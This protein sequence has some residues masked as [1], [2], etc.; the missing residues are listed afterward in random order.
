MRDA[1]SIRFA[2]VAGRAR[3]ASPAEAIRLLPHEWAF[4][5]LYAF[6]IARL[7]FAA[8]F[9]APMLGWLTLAATTLAL[10]AL[11][12]RFATPATRS[13]RLGAYIVLMNA[14]YF[15]VRPTVLATTTMRFDATLA[16]LDTAL[17]GAPLPLVAASLVPS[18]ANDLLGACYLLLFP[19]IV[20]SCTWF[21]LR[22]G[23]ADDRA[24]ERFF[25]AVF[26]TYAAGFAGYLLVPAAGPWVA[27]AGGFRGPL[28]GG[29]LTRLT[30]DVVRQGSTQVDVFPSLHVAVSAVIAAHLP[31]RSTWARLAV[32]IPTLGLWLSTVALRFHYGVDAVAGFLLAVAALA[33][34]RRLV[35]SSTQV[36]A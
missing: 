9:G 36:H 14:A 22:A 25:A 4:A 1:L 26:I 15:A 21:A 30:M 18:W 19:M 5:A 34:S 28:H 8:S 10:A 33:I 16:R 23:R 12:A 2:A 11:D 29:A 7:A 3:S 27:M 13:L 35:P 20:A 24:S 31:V 17:F 6:A 32:A